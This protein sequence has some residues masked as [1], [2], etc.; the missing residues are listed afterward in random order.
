MYDHYGLGIGEIGGYWGHTGEALG[1][2]SA[3]MHHPERGITIAVLVNATPAVS[4]GRSDNI[5]E[6]IFGELAEVVRQ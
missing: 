2:Q 5:A 3:V 6:E 4:E 1:F